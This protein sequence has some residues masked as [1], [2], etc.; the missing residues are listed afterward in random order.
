[1][2]W[3]NSHLHQFTAKGKTYEIPDEAFLNPNFENE[4]NFKLNKILNTLGDSII[5][6][7]DFGDTWI[8]QISLE[9]K[10]TL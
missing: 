6:E 9:K 3:T 1:M 10:N 7:Y 8:H 2:G 4:N 5:Y